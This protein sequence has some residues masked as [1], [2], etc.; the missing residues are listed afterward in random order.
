MLVLGFIYGQKD[1]YYICVVQAASEDSVELV[2]LAEVSR[3]YSRKPA[4]KQQLITAAGTIQ[5]KDGADTGVQV[6]ENGVQVQEN[7]TKLE[8]NGTE[9]QVGKKFFIQINMGEKT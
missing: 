6:Q 7:G 5:R 4:L 3:T 2:N 1:S 9:E 8:E